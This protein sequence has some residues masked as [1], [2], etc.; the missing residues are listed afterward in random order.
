MDSQT[1]DRLWQLPQ[2]Q[3]LP[4][5]R[6]LNLHLAAKLMALRQV[7]AS[8][9]M[10]A[11]LGILSRRYSTCM[12]AGRCAPHNFEQRWQSIAS[13]PQPGPLPPN[14]MPSGARQRGHVGF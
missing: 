5:Q 3:R 4:A 14:A 11:M 2:A 9:P 10:V 8:S 12:P 7:A 13:R 1:R 6:M